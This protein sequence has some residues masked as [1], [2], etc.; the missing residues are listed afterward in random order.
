MKNNFDKNYREVYFQVGDLVL[1]KLQPYLQLFLASNKDKKLSPCYYGLFLVEVK[2]GTV[3]YRL[4]FPMTVKIHQVFHVSCL[5]N[6]Q[7]SHVD[8]APNLPT[9]HKEKYFKPQKPFSK[10]S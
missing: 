2:I 6:F 4:A 8:A 5:K 9:I 10:K 1:L 3:A 7:G